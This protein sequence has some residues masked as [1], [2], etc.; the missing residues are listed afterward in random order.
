MKYFFTFFLV[1]EISLTCL[2][3]KFTMN[4]GGTLQKD[5]FT[6][7]PYENV[8]DKI[9]VS[10]EINEKKRRFMLDTGAP[11]AITKTLFDEID[12]III[13]K[14]PVRDQSEKM[15]TLAVASV[16]KITFGGVDFEDVPAL[17]LE[18]NSRTAADCFGIDG[19]IGSNM[20]RKSIVQFDSKSK[21]I[22]LTDDAKKLSLNKKES[23]DLE[24]NT[25]QSSPL[26]QIRVKKEKIV[27]ET[28]L[29]DTGANTFYDLSLNSFNVFKKNGVV[30]ILSESVGSNS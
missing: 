18:N 23:S 19:L 22:T 4:Q 27:K 21:T 6:V 24:L 3:Q 1:V 12:A 9:I 17:V 16:N 29:F 2:A 20:L 10:V 14:I 13:K 15:D 11:N 28:L 30:N 8:N 7:I 5:Y 25:H 26:V